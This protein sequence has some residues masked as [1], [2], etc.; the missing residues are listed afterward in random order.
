[1]E[2]VVH[3]YKSATSTAFK[4]A[5]Q[6]VLVALSHQAT[7]DGYEKKENNF[8]FIISKVEAN[9]VIVLLVFTSEQQDPKQYV[10]TIPV[11]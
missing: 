8:K 7:L 11:R 1:M 6:E 4:D 9:W 2:N 10:E 3:S 5:I